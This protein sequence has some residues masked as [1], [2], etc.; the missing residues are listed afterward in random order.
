MA[1]QRIRIKLRSYDHAMLDQSASTEWKL[2][3]KYPVR[4]AVNPL[5]SG[6][7]YLF[8]FLLSGSVIVSV[9]LGLPTVGPLLL[10]A[11]MA[12]DLFMAAT[13]VMLLGFMTVIG[14]LISDIVLA[15]IDPRIRM[16]QR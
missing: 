5:V 12:E 1:T 16:E 4:I 15:L 9:V 8:P 13:I 2:I 6:A 14:T 3:L 10:R 7:A 11:L